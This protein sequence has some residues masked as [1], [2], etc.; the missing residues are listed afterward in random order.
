MG[1]NTA[2]VLLYISIFTFF[3]SNSYYGEHYVVDE[4][5]AKRQKQIEQA[6][7]LLKS[8]DFMP[9]AGSAKST[10]YTP[11]V[12][13]KSEPWIS[14][15]TALLL[16]YGALF[17]AISLFMGIGAS[18]G[19]RKVNPFLFIS[20]LVA[21]F[22]SK[23][24][25][26]SEWFKFFGLYPFKAAL[27]VSQ[28]TVGISKFNANR[29][30]KASGGFNFEDDHGA[31]QP[32]VN[33]E[34]HTQTEPSESSDTTKLQKNS[35]RISKTK[36]NEKRYLTASMLKK[37]PNF[38]VDSGSLTGSTKYNSFS[39]CM[40]ASRT[41]FRDKMVKIYIADKNGVGSQ[42]IGYYLNGEAI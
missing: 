14:K 10:S 22:F 19:G 39:D 8:S 16:M 2:M 40:D 32:Q 13:T 30:D 17:T 29:N 20:A 1:I 36:A 34:S 25:G 41:Q 6:G 3:G 26:F 11:P 28:W 21:P 5:A 37:Y 9:I 35:A 42:E 4:T 15:D 27:Y 38:K 23:K 12:A 24:M 7:F 31:V 33:T 18:N